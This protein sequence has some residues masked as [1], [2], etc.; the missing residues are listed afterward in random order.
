MY[1]GE[2]LL[3]GL[4]AQPLSRGLKTVAAMEGV[5]SQHTESSNISLKSWL[6]CG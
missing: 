4:R 2:L 1:P 6:R 5:L 3:T